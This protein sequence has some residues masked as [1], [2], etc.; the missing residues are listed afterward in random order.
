MNPVFLLSMITKAINLGKTL[1]RTSP[2]GPILIKSPPGTKVFLIRSKTQPVDLS[3][4]A[5]R[6][7]I[8]ELIPDSK[9][10]FDEVPESRYYRNCHSGSR[11]PMWQGSGSGE[12]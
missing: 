7:K 8:Q 10:P 2:A 3:K 11:K 9:F 6:C 4:Y 1:S 12:N 5:V